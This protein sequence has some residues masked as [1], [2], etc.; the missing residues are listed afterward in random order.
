MKEIPG[1]KKRVSG[2]ASRG[3][4]LNVGDLEDEEE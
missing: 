2:V 4:N 1:K 3:G